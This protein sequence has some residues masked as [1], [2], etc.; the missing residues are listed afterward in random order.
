MADLAKIVDD[1]SKLTVLEAAEL[2]K[3]MEEAF[4]VSAAAPVMMGGGVARAEKLVS[5][6][7]AMHAEAG[8]LMGGYVDLKEGRMAKAEAAAV[9]ARPGAN[10]ELLE[11]HEALLVNIASKYL[12]DKK[13]GDAERVLRDA[14]RRFPDS[15]T[16]PY[17]MGRTLQEQGK[18]RE[19]ITA[20]EPLLAKAPRAYM[21]YRIG[22]SLQALGETGKA[23]AAYEKA[24][25][26]KPAL[27]QK[28]RAEAATRLKAVK[29]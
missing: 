15:D 7:A 18:H 8:K 28:L 21:H 9:T 2:S 23:A 12:N 24:L 26:F 29:G 27:N 4:G 17:M 10:D 6:T 3:A 11:R 1:L 16:P 5:E 13:Y 14:A 19:A 20:I 25:A 22:Q